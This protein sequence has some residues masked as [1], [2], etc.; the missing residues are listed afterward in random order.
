MPGHAGGHL[1]LPAA[2][3]LHL[4]QTLLALQLLLGEHP[5]DPFFTFCLEASHQA[6]HVLQIFAETFFLGQ[7]ADPRSA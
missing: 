1:E 7:V 5:G 3:L 4:E 2:L 6:L